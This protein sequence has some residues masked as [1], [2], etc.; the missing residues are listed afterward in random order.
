MELVRSRVPDEVDGAGVG[1]EA[2]ERGPG[3]DVEDLDEARV[4][5]GGDEAAVGAEGGRGGGVGE[6]GNGGLGLFQGLERGEEGE[7]GGVG[8]GEEVGKGGGEGEGG[9]GGD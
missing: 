4:G 7:G 6:G 3:L 1:A 9:Y 5:S 8:G 2:A